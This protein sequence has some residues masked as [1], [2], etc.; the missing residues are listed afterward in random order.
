MSEIERFNT[1]A[2]AI[3]AS[4]RT[5]TT[6]LKSGPYYCTGTASVI[7][8]VKSGE[9]FPASPTGATVTWTMVGSSTSFTSSGSISTVESAEM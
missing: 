5:G 6:C 7:V 8:F 2:T 3:T 1:S 4:G 9:K